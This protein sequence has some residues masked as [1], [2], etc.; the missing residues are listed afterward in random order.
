MAKYEGKCP[1]CNRIARSD[2]KG[3]VVVCDCWKTCPECGQPMTPYVPDLAA[4]T[5]G[6]DGQ[7][8]LE[9]L[10]V[11]ARHSP[12]FLSSQKPVEVVCT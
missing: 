12:I 2:R 10:M 3:D 7:R 4:N 11:C 1:R 8:D 9:V 5:Y 6:S